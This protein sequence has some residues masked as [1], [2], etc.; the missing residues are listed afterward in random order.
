MT[1]IP[2]ATIA[3]AI[4]AAQ[5]PYNPLLWSAPM[6][7]RLSSHVCCGTPKT[8]H[9]ALTLF[10]A[11]GDPCT[12]IGRQREGRHQLGPRRSRG[13]AQARAKRDKFAQAFPVGGAHDTGVGK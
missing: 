12:R 8:R 3:A 10:W 9:G 4:A 1:A 2:R 6:R 7:L 5:N 13:F 11:S